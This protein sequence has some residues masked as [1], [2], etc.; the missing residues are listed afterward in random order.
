MSAYAGCILT[1]RAIMAAK[2]DFSGKC[3]LAFSEMSDQ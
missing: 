2:H 3:S 1:L